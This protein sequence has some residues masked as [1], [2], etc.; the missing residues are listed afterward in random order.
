MGWWGRAALLGILAA[1]T[2]SQG[3]LLIVPLAIML[4]WGPRAD[5]KPETVSVAWW[6]PKYRPRLREAVAVA[7]I[8]LGVLAYMAYIRAARHA[9]RTNGP[10]QGA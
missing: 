6:R 5:R 2:R 8:P 1:A 7:A 10:V 4:L 3:V 9:L